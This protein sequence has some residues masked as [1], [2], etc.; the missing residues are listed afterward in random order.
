MGR[1]KQK[2]RKPALQDYS[3]PT[4]A[5]RESPHAAPIWGRELIDPAAITQMENAMRLPVTVAG[6]LMPDAHVGYGIPIG[7][8]VALDNAVAP[9]MVGVD[10]ACR[11]HMS[12]FSGD[13][14][15]LI[16][17]ASRREQLKRAMRQETRFGIGAAFIGRGRREHDV[18][19]DV[20]WG[21]TKAM[22]WLKDKAW[23]QLG[24]S[25]SG[26]HF[27]DAGMLVPE[28]DEAARILGLEPGREHFAFMSHSGSRGAGAQIADHYS[29]L[30]QQITP[31]PL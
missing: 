1:K 11:M 8:V 19:E 12:I 6:A 20:D 24:T 27:L 4:I 15:D 2:K 13:H 26:N 5:V 29:K 7:G 25:G 16:E 3:G 17:N 18:M 9:Y 23:D 22:T 14:L 10:I 21:L 28:S 31:L 30:A